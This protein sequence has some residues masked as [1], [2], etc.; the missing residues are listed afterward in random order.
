[1]EDKNDDNVED[2]KVDDTTRTYKRANGTEA[3]YKVSKGGTTNDKLSEDLETT[4]QS[5]LDEGCVEVKKSEMKDVKLS[6]IVRYVTKDG[7]ARRGGNL[8]KVENDYFRLLNSRNGI[9]WSVQFENT[10]RIFTRV[11]MGKRF[12]Q[13]DGEP[14]KRTWKKKPTK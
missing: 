6:N 13:K 4:I 12:F 11:I 14:S 1:M 10:D 7:K 9:S 5:W 8:I 2:K 3:S